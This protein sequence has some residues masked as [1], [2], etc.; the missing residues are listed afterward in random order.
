MIILLIF[1]ALT[2]NIAMEQL[3]FE[4]MR[5]TIANP[6]DW[7]DYSLEDLEK[8]TIASDEYNDGKMFKS[9]CDGAGVCEYFWVDPPDF[10]LDGVDVF[11]EDGFIPNYDIMECKVKSEIKTDPFVENS[12]LIIALISVILISATAWIYFFRCCFHNTKFG[13]DK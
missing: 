2:P 5:D 12:I 11:C 7:E 10:I 9:E 8:W 1:L 6:E 13:E 3:Q 4:E